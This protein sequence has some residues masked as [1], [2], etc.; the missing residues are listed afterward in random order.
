MAEQTKLTCYDASQ[1][2]ISAEKQAVIWIKKAHAGSVQWVDQC[3]EEQFYYYCLLKKLKPLWAFA[4]C[5]LLVVMLFENP[6]PC[7]GSKEACATLDTSL[8]AW[9]IAVLPLQASACIYIVLYSILLGRMGLR[10]LALGSVYKFHG[11][12]TWV[13]AIGLI[14]AICGL[15][16]P[17]IYMASFICRPL[18]FLG[19]TKSLRVTVREVFR[20]VPSFMDVIITLFICVFLFASVGMVLFVDTSEGVTVFNTWRN[21]I[22]RMWVLFTTNNSPNVFI[23]AYGS[24]RLYFFYFLFYLVFMIYVLANVLLAKVYDAYKVM[25]KEDLQ[26]FQ[27]HQNTSIKNA[28]ACLAGGHNHI[29]AEEWNKFF[30]EYCDPAIGGVQVE[31]PKDSK[32]N[33]WRA[34][35]ILSVF[36]GIDLERDKKGINLEQFRTIMEVFLD[37]EVFIP[38][39]RPTSKNITSDFQLTMYKFYNEGLTC[40]GRKVTWDEMIDMTIIP[41][42]MVTLWEAYFFCNG[43]KVIHTP[44][45]WIVFVFS[46][47]YTLSLSMKISQLGMER[48][49]NRHAIQHRFDFFNVYGLIIVELLYMIAFRNKVMEKAVLLLSLGRVLRLCKYIKP[50][51]H[52]FFVIKRLLPTYTSICRLLMILFFIAT[53]VGQLAFGGKIYNTNPLLAGTSFAQS[54]FWTMNFNDCASGLVTLFVMMILNNWTDLSLG[55]CAACR[56]LW[57]VAFFIGFFVV[58]NLVVLNILMALILEC[59][60]VLS[61]EVE[62][63]EANGKADANGEDVERMASGAGERSAVFMLRKVLCSDDHDV[64]KD[65]PSSDTE[66][67]EKTK[68]P[69]PGDAAAYGTFGESGRGASRKPIDRRASRTLEDLDPEVGGMHSSTIPAGSHGHGKAKTLEDIE[70]AKI[71]EGLDPAA[72]KEM[73]TAATMLQSKFRGMMSRRTATAKKAEDADPPSGSSAMSPPLLPRRP[74]F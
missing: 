6:A 18:L 13:A 31:D 39:R 14:G 1:T 48:F 44:N 57:P 35:V 67:E 64:H 36:H 63:E 55:Y 43:R 15:F 3:S 50:L 56:S 47:F 54:D 52:L 16:S 19:C 62:A 59:F 34:N 45:F 61:Q 71:T 17:T 66:E 73:D 25:L 4:K 42:T 49:W 12:R 65:T 23:P 30:V 10:V 51:Q 28:F 29:S 74:S 38:K 22:S 26:I 5:M 32:Y 40:C 21:A 37:R 20:A 46:L 9:P 68:S 24:N 7:I 53:S 11:G 8:Y 58:C 70:A 2:F 41:G 33:T 69:K 72:K 60:S 27:D